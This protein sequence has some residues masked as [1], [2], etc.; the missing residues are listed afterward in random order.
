MTLCQKITTILARMRNKPGKDN[1]MPTSTASWS[2]VAAAYD[3]GRA[4]LGSSTP[5]GSG[6]DMVWIMPWAVH[7]ARQAE[8]VDATRGSPAVSELTPGEQSACARLY[9]AIT[10]TPVILNGREHTYVGGIVWTEAFYPTEWAVRNGVVVTRDDLMSLPSS[11]N[12]GSW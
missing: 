8:G 4:Q 6:K 3:A 2:Q 7:Q 5:L 1:F 10:H 9:Y 12:A 11:N